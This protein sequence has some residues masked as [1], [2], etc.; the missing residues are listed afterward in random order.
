MK[1]PFES[2]TGTDT[3]TAVPGTRALQ[4][5]PTGGKA[6]A[7]LR[8]FSGPRGLQVIADPV[9]EPPADDDP[10]AATK[11]RRGAGKTVAAAAPDQAA[12]LAQ[13]YADAAM[14]LGALE[15]AAP[16]PDAAPATEA[17]DGAA[18]R[19]GPA[20]APRGV[21]P[22]W[23][24][25]G[26]VYMP[27]GQTYGSN[28]GRTIV[29]GRV[30]SIAVDPSNGNHLLC[31]SAAGG[32]WESFDNGTTWWPRTDSAP[33]LTV[34][35]LAYAKSAPATVYCGTGEGNFYA[36]L[37]AGVLKSVNGGTTWSLVAGAPFVGQG[38]YDLVVDPVNVN[39]VLAGT[40]SGLYESTN[41]GVAW[42]LRRAR[43][44]WSLAYQTSGGA[45]AEVL[46]ACS[47][48]VYRSTNGGTTWAAVALP[49]APASWNRLAVS[50]VRGDPRVAYAF[51]SSGGAA[52][53]YR[54]DV[55]G[56]WSA[57][58]LPAGVSVGQDWYDWCLMAAPD[59]VNQV[60]V[61]SIDNFRG[62]LS[63]GTW[64]WMA[65]SAK[66]SGDSIHPDQHAFALHPTDP[67]VLFAGSDGGLYRS[68]NRG[69]NWT[70]LNNGLAITEI[71]YLA[72]DWGSTRM[73]LAGTQDNGTIRYTGSAVWEHAQDGDGG[74]CG[75]NRPS[76]NVCFHTF[77]GMGMERSTTGGGWGSWG[78][79]GPAVPAGYNALFY[80]PVEVNGD[81][82][83]QAGQSVFVSR[84]RGTA[85]TQVALPAGLVATAMHAPTPDRLYVGVSAGR[86]FRLDWNG[87]S[88]VVTELTAPRL[89][90]Q[91]S[92]IHVES[93][94]PNNV[95][96]TYRASSGGR[97]Y[98]STN[99]GTA[100]TDRSAGL[101]VLPINAVCTDPGNAGRVW[102]AAD[103]GVYESLSSGAAW[104]VLGTGLPNV[105]VADLV[106]HPHARVLRAGTRNR[107]VWEV[108]VD[109]WMTAPICGTQ[110]TGT[111]AGNQTGRWFTFNW[112]ATWHVVWTV[113]PVSPT[114]A[115][116]QLR[117]TVQVERGSSEYA[118]YWI[119]VTNLTPAAVQFEGRYAI[120]SRY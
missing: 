113:M 67:N 24:S 58:A 47:D 42:T 88:W 2:D 22:A 13:R 49:G 19:D 16:M 105:M 44:T 66:T 45:A 62:T 80:P 68:P 75:L 89:G 55:A 51:G 56:V 20:P 23:R 31:G 95:W 4:P 103:I 77:Y 94:A 27:N 120:L 38:F 29:S 85:F 8:E 36:G 118:T 11:G 76:P 71:E 18:E 64:T 39:H 7:R 25:L 90:A 59:T 102:V 100:W 21:P 70:S 110:F 52:R 81:T 104:S 17:P 82:V 79:I 98:A 37:G 60:Y 69:V 63:A 5:K 83:A 112:P 117:W 15:A 40:T 57:V 92:D 26:P 35:A 32:V 106:F 101:P 43:R 114:S 107:G 1:T 34:G 41:G 30:S 99:G 93:G 109:G 119:N 46:A 73:L 6:L 50:M 28:P 78:W 33:T 65:M 10:P 86:V 12:E 87:A 3:A 115:T 97:V 48:G 84:N 54:R 14:A 74:D 91:V 9:A 96:V 108:P 61:G 53:L 116:P 111:I 72:Q